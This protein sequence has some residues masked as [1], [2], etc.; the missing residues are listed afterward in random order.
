MINLSDGFALRNTACCWPGGFVT[1]KGTVRLETD[2]LILRRFAME[3]IR[4]IFDNCWSDPEVW[5][6][7]LYKPMRCVEDVINA[8]E[9]FTDGWLGAYDRPN[10]Y[11]WAVQ[12]KSSGEVI[13]RFFGMY[14]D[15]QLRQIELAY[16]IGRNWWNQGLTTEAA[17]AVIDFFF[18]DV[19]FNRICSN[20]A[21]ENP[22]S[23]MVMKKCGMT[24]EGTMRQA[25]RCNKGIFDKV[26]YA[27]LAE[28]YFRSR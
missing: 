22:A 6:M 7:T 28:D 23:G 4:Q 1:H 10:R 25:L 5:Q 12:L 14:P 11:S 2:R 26:N 18:T 24:Y 3:D 20:H 15:D 13:G 17:K 16:E 21:P 9:M 8:A 27:I 19:G